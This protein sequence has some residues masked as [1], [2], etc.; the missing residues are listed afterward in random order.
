M[1]DSHLKLE[2]YYLINNG[3]DGSRGV[4][5]KEFSVYQLICDEKISDYCIWNATTLLQGKNIVTMQAQS[6]FHHADESEPVG[7][8]HTPELGVQALV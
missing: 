7:L 4:S 5:Q 2:S 8:E 6:K 1:H 3:V